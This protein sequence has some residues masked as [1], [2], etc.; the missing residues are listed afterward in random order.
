MSKE[1]KAASLFDDDDDD[2]D[3]LFVSGPP[4]S[5]L[6][7]AHG[8]IHQCPAAVEPLLRIDARVGD[9]GSILEHFFFFDFLLCPKRAQASPQRRNPRRPHPCSRTTMRMRTRMKEGRKLLQTK[10]RMRERTRVS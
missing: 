7:V 8:P 6:V 2:E 3:A 5:Q 1:K 10:L 4:M 9:P